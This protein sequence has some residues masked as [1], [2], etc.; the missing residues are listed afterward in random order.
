MTPE[1]KAKELY[2][3]HSEAIVLFS[4]EGGLHRSRAKQCA[5][6]TVE[7]ILAYNK[8]LLEVF[9][10]DPDGYTPTYWQEVKYHLQNH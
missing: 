5:L 2:E 1:E 9:P 6:I 4:K 3:K 8:I 10:P 7:E